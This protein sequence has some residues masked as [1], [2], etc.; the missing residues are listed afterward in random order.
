MNQTLLHNTIVVTIAPSEKVREESCLW[1][2][3]RDRKRVR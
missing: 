1:G 2:Y 3:A